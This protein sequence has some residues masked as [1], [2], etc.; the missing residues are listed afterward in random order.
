MPTITWPFAKT[1]LRMLAERQRQLVGREGT[2]RRKLSN[3]WLEEY[4]GV[5]TPV[6]ATFWVNASR[7]L[8]P[9]TIADVKNPNIFISSFK[10][11]EKRKQK[12]TRKY[13]PLLLPGWMECTASCVG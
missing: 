5:G 1:I 13:V 6:G 8:L 7:V 4:S 12:K 10:E 2:G 9:L 11:K 3:M